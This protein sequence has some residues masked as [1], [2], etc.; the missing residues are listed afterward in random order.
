[1]KPQFQTHADFLL[2]Y[3]GKQAPKVGSSESQ[4][5]SSGATTPIDYVS[6]K[7]DEFVKAET[8]INSRKETI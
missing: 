4:V 2:H 5:K 8:S 7:M 3:L 6:A 1:M